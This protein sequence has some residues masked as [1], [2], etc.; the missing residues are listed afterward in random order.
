MD[1]KEIENEA[2]QNLIVKKSFGDRFFSL[3][4]LHGLLLSFSWAQ[5]VGRIFVTNPF[6]SFNGCW[7][8]PAYKTLDKTAVVYAVDGVSTPPFPMK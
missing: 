7:T 6:T 3:R 8:Y 2:R 4:M 1:I 5:M